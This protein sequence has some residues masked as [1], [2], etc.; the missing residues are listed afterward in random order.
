MCAVPKTFCRISHH[1]Q[2]LPSMSLS[3]PICTTCRRL[4]LCVCVCLKC[5]GDGI[6]ADVCVS[7]G[8]LICRRGASTVPN[9]AEMLS[10]IRSIRKVFYFVLFYFVRRGTV[11]LYEVNVSDLILLKILK[12]SYINSSSS[13]FYYLNYFL[14]LALAP[15]LFMN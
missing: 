3:C 5:A 8:W 12:T 13:C 10:I 14:I 11:H 4:C 15:N 6:C 1:L 9:F 7:R 2:P